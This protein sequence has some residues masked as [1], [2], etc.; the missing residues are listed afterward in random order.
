M[1]RFLNYLM[2]TLLLVSCHKDGLNSQAH[3]PFPQNITYPAPHITPSN[4]NRDELNNTIE[5]FYQQWKKI[6][7][8]QCPNGDYYVD[9]TNEAHNTSTVSEAIG[10]GMMIEA[11]MAGSDP[12]AKE[13]FDGLLSFYLHHPST[14]CP[15]FMAWSQ[16]PDC[17]NTG[18]DS[19]TDGDKDVA[20]ALLLADKQWGSTDQYDYKAIALRI[21]NALK[22]CAF[23]NQGYPL[24]GD[25]VDSQDTTFAAATRS[26]DWMPDHYI[27]F[28]KYTSDPF[29]QQATDEIINIAT[30]IQETYS[31]QTGLIPD[32]IIHVGTDPRPAY[33]DLLESPHDGHYYYNACRTPW[34]LTIGYLFSGDDSLRQIINKINSWIMG[35]TGGDA[36]Q[37]TA[38]YR[39][40]GTAIHD[41]KDIAF[42]G[43][44]AVATMA[45]SDQQW[46]DACLTELIT[47]ATEDYTYYG[48]TLRLLYLLVIS[49]NYWLP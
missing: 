5:D 35:K 47:P 3:V 14:I 16:G 37:I 25:W 21:I 26:S 46:L 41:F 10:Y 40:D 48:N 27:T 42:T 49:G 13:I 12:E 18:F 17:Q 1:K 32:F 30:S 2:L 9:L 7:I 23:S 8:N 43:G 11:Y 24:L 44:L 38:G 45:G 20:F 39:L 29:W 4:M 34:R 19:A 28:Y 31:P 6:Y 36:S 15:T 22:Q 33:P